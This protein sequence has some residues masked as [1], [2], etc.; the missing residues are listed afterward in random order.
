MKEFKDKLIKKLKS[1]GNQIFKKFIEYFCNYYNCF[2]ENCSSNRDKTEDYKNEILSLIFNAKQS[3][4]LTQEEYK[5]AIFG[6]LG[7]KFDDFRSN[8]IKI[9]S[10]FKFEKFLDLI[11][12]KGVYA[13]LFLDFYCT[14]RDNFSKYLSESENI[15]MENLDEIFSFLEDNLDMCD[16]EAEPVLERDIIFD[17]DMTSLIQSYI[18]KEDTIN[19]SSK[20]S[21][22]DYYEKYCLTNIKKCI[23]TS[24]YIL[25]DFNCKDKYRNYGDK[26]ATALKKNNQ[27]LYGFWD[28]K[29]TI[30]N[31]LK[32]FSGKNGFTINTHLQNNSG[33]VY[34]GMSLSQAKIKNFNKKTID[35]II[36]AKNDKPIS[37]YPID[38]DEFK[39]KFK[40]L[41]DKYLKNI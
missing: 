30:N 19:Y 23:P 15:S 14:A 27:H 41:C 2:N 38:Y 40:L 32:L 37:I 8:L 9:L 5:N 12:T 16:P 25:Y 17:K 31:I 6:V 7:D 18:H 35:I 22:N 4:L 36:F 39:H 1:Q 29:K 20:N 11:K 26:L 21:F 10:I 33:F 24:N 3:I 28:F 34:I 13:E